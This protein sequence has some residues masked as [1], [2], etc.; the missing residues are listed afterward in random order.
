MY[1]WGKAKEREM[2]TLKR[3]EV[4]GFC[5]FIGA[6]KLLYVLVTTYATI[7][8]IS[9]LEM[10]PLFVAGLVFATRMFDAFNDPVIGS[11]IDK[12]K[13]RYKTYLNITAVLLPL[14]TVLVFV[15][16]FEST[17]AVYAFATIM[18]VIWSVLYTVSEVPIY[19]IVS[20]MTDD[21]EDQDF[22]FSISTVGSMIGMFFGLFL[23]AFYL[24]NGVDSIAWI[25]FALS[26]GIFG[27]IQM[28]FTVMFVHEKIE[29][30]KA[31]NSEK[32]VDILSKTFSNKH[33]LT[34]M[35]IYLAQLFVNAS[36]VVSVYV[37]DGYYGMPTL[38]TIAGM[39]GMIAIIPFALLMP[40]LIKSFGK[41]NLIYL[42]SGLL[43]IPNI[44][45]LLLGLTG[46][47][48]IP[49]LVLSQIGLVT[50]SILRP[51]YAQECIN[52]QLEA[53]GH[54][55]QAAS[56]SLMTFFNKAG[57]A[58]GASLGSLF[59]IIAGFDQTIAVGSQSAETLKTLQ[60][61]NFLGPI[62]MGI[63]WYIGIRYFY[64]LKNRKSI[65]E[66]LAKLSPEVYSYDL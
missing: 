45:I 11:L 57:D 49:F 42:S 13:T 10:S 22:I 17:F 52:Y 6:E 27:F 51:L 20:H 28:L 25:P 54:S 37:Y 53:T 34:I 64:K 5:S 62:L 32:L 59:L 56:F 21:K 36:A 9:K 48:L 24:R 18:Y 35:I 61:L 1:N 47:N 65:E 26:F 19:S 3:R 46:S 8:Y 55:N 2:K 29:I 44:L 63:T 15:N 30:K 66:E 12:G 14:A 4:F 60:I 39:V 43:I 38:G 23:F 33:L 58:I 16:P 31:E 41:T 40:R 7:F 50:P